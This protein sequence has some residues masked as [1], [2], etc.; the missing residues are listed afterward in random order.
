[1][2]TKL[3]VAGANAR[4]SL[5]ALILIAFFMTVS[6]LKVSQNSDNLSIKF[7]IVAINIEVTRHLSKKRFRSNLIFMRKNIQFYTK[8]EDFLEHPKSSSFRMIISKKHLTN[9][10]VKMKL[11]NLVKDV[12]L[13]KN[14]KKARIKTIG[15]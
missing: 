12:Y 4:C 3:I 9:P 5:F 10:L 13:T 2:S 7:A 1:M 8:K 15:K 6:S 11:R 14:L